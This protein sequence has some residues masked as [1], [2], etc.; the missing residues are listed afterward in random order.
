MIILLP[1]PP[2]VGS[3]A[4]MATHGFTHSLEFFKNLIQR[5]IL[6]TEDRRWALVQVSSETLYYRDQEVRM[7]AREMVQGVRALTV[8]PKVLSSNLSNHMVAHNH[9]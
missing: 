1:Q 9:L 3:W 5:Y 4:C 7:G 6:E 2:S 8:L